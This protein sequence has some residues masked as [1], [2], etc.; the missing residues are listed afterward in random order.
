MSGCERGIG[1]RVMSY[2]ITGPFV[3]DKFR[4][5]Q[6]AVRLDAGSPALHIAKAD[7]LRGRSI[8]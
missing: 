2:G 1:A 4:Q 5:K 6:E 8:G 3:S 7:L